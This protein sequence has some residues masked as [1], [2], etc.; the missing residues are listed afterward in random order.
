MTQVC[1]P[2]G[3]FYLSL[4]KDVSKWQIFMD[5]S[6]SGHVFLHDVEIQ[7][8]STSWK[9]SVKGW[10][11]SWRDPI[12]N[13]N[14]FLMVK[15]ARFQNQGCE[16]WTCKK[17]STWKLTLDTVRMSRSKGAGCQFTLEWVLT[18]D[19][20]NRCVPHGQLLILVPWGMSIRWL[21]QWDQG[22]TYIQ[23]FGGTCS[24]WTW[25]TSKTQVKFFIL[26]SK[27]TWKSRVQPQIPH[28][29]LRSASS[30]IHLN[31]WIL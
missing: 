27:F 4:I 30:G 7:M 2:S 6:N 29:N 3:H 1:R 10:Y 5:R 19:W 12:I 24:H 28:E 15:T 17:T 8:S 20:W 13:L 26:T 21:F 22:R 25:S 31:T 11:W 14:G 23:P 16:L 18:G 9:G